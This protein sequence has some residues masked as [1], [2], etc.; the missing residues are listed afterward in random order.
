MADERPLCV[1]TQHLRCPGE[2]LP[3]LLALLS[4]PLNVVVNSVVLPL[5]NTLLQRGIPIPQICADLAGYKL[6]VN[7]SR[8]EIDMSGGTFALVGADANIT[9][10]PPPI[11]RHVARRRA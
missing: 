9:L 10:V 1:L 4:A 3:A 8:P 5:A 7:L 2:L 6:T 11:A